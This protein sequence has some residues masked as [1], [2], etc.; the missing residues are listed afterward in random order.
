MYKGLLIHSLHCF[1]FIELTLFIKQ[2]SYD[3]IRI[4]IYIE[5]IS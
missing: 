2:V 1:E 5:R 3:K 4:H